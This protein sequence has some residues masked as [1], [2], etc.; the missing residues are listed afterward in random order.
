MSFTFHGLKDFISSS[1]RLYHG[2]SRTSVRLKLENNNYLIFLFLSCTF[3]QTHRLERKKLRKSPTRPEMTFIFN[4][5]YRLML[6]EIQDFPL[7]QSM[8][9]G[10]TVKMQNQARFWQVHSK[11]DNLT[12]WKIKNYWEKTRIRINTSV[13]PVGNWKGYQ[14]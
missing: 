5:S 12:G 2:K 10:G 11:F 7:Y 9:P 6:C 1:L 3:H 4:K 8:P 14:V 13:W